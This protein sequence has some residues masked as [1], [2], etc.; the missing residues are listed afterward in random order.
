MW[1]HSCSHPSSK[2]TLFLECCSRS[3]V[4]ENSSSTPHIWFNIYADNWNVYL[5]NWTVV[6]I[7]FKCLFLC[8]DREQNRY[9]IIVT[10]RLW[11]MA[12]ISG[13]LNVSHPINNKMKFAF[14]CDTHMAIL[15]PFIS[16][17]LNLITVDIY[18]NF[19]NL[20]MHIP[21]YVYT[22]NMYTC[23]CNDY[24]IIC[25]HLYVMIIW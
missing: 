16:M 24:M 9:A 11:H 4:G 21:M 13:V 8:N 22:D 15:E 6:L 10:T 18:L 17:L 19:T 14:C 12:T 25:I 3:R 20:R 2:R 1:E 7:R 23:I 5:H